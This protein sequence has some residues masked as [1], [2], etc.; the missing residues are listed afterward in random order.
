MKKFFNLNTKAGVAVGMVIIML[1]ATNVGG[2]TIN[3]SYDTALLQISNSMGNYSSVTQAHLQRAVWDCNVSHGGWVMLPQDHGLNTV[4]L[5]NP[6]SV[7]LINMSG[8]NSSKWDSGVGIVNSFKGKWNATSSNLVTYGTGWNATRALVQSKSAAW[9]ASSTNTIQP[10]AY[11]WN[12]TKVTLLAS[13]PLWN[14]T[15]S[16]LTTMSPLWNTTRSTWAPLWNSTRAVVSA[17]SAT[18]NA[19]ASNLVSY[20]LI[21]NAS[22]TTL[23]TSAPLWNNTKSVVFVNGPL[24]NATRSLLSSC[25]PLWNS[26]RAVVSAKSAAWNST[27]DVVTAKRVAWNAS[28]SNLVSYGLLW[29]N[30][31]SV[32]FTNGPGWNNTKSVVTSRMANWNTSYNIVNLYASKWNATS[33]LVT[34]KSAAWNLSGNGY[35]VTYIT[36][37]KGNYWTATGANLQDAFDDLNNES[38]KVKLPICDLELTTYLR[39]GD[40]AWLDGMGNGSVLRLA[41]DANCSIIRNY[42]QT[43]GNNDLKFSNFRIEGNCEGQDVYY[44][45]GAGNPWWSY[46][47][48]IYLVNCDYVEIYGVT[49]NGTRSQ[50]ILA[51][52]CRHVN[53]YGCFF[54]EIGVSYDG[55]G[56]A[57]YAADAIYYYNTTDSVITT[58]IN[59]NAYSVGFVIEGYIDAPSSY[60]SRNVT[61]SGCVSTDTGV[62]YYVEDAS[63]V[64]FDHNTVSCGTDNSCFGASTASGFRI[65]TDCDHITVS[66]N[67]I[68]DTYRGI[69][70]SADNYLIIKG[71]QIND[72]YRGIDGSCSHSDISHNVV[73]YCTTYGMN[74]DGHNNSIDHNYIYQCGQWSAGIGIIGTEN[75]TVT[76]NHIVG[77]GGQYPNLGIYGANSDK[78]SIILFNKFEK[79]DS[80]I[81]QCIGRLNCTGYDDW[82]FYTGVS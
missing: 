26:T 25:S 28:A 27:A 67:I 18:W 73:T 21:W 43:N 55:T 19:S 29:N 15:R 78:N 38:G 82:N 76:F 80:E 9:N 16:L 59:D 41:D 69:Q 42:D 24:W 12:A 33:A 31:K 17:K 23:L 3:D 63:F 72:T 47:V 61:V 64:V 65:A 57:H 8:Y 71:N 22:R 6:W 35:N 7:A 39:V 2:R 75:M 37:S 49:I 51:E 54:T 52:K 50:G 32:L 10:F 34:A 77:I 30:T 70:V 48:G 58:C 46:A 62:G 13:S 14:A 20:G 45:S 4:I 11:I 36:N 66:D 1:L 53:T 74:F 40:G 81:Y 60:R 79:V 44:G 5:N 56:Y 68:V